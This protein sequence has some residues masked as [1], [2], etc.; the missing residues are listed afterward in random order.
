[1]TRA[2]FWCRV[3]GWL[4]IIS[5]ALVALVVFLLWSLFKDW[6]DIDAVAILVFFKW[7]AIFFLALPPLLSGLFTVLFANRV[8]Q[9]REGLRGQGAWPLRILMILGGLWSAG[10]IGFAGLGLP[11]VTVLAVLAIATVVMGIGGP[12]WT[13]DLLVRKEPAS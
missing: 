2:D 12:E 10:V 9:A 4:Q 8:E 13:A 5:G 1:M 3:I 11:P 7:L 6:L